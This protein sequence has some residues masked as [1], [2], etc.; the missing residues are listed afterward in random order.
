M[1]NYGGTHEFLQV[2]NTTLDFWKPNILN[3]FQ[4]LWS[5]NPSVLNPDFSVAGNS[6]YCRDRGAV[7]NKAATSFV[8]TECCTGGRI[9]LAGGIS[10]GAYGFVSTVKL[11]RMSFAVG[12][13]LPR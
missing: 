6:L 3:H 5:L 13:P 10:C 11:R 9:P 12:R 2:Y 7:R 1:G 4:C 8:K